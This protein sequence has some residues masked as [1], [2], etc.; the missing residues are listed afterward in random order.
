MMRYCFQHPGS[1][2]FVISQDGEVRVIT[3]VRDALIIW[4]NIK[5]KYYTYPSKKK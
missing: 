5:L 1:I 3:K 4:E 2:G